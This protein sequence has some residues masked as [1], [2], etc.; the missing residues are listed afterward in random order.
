MKRKLKQSWSEIPPILTKQTITFHLNSLNIKRGITTYD[1][2][3]S[4]P[5]VGQ[6][7]TCSGV[8]LVNVI[9]T[10]PYKQF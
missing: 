5:G 3:N 7:Q 2:I 8:K 10:I 4:D 6:A 9:S 1:V